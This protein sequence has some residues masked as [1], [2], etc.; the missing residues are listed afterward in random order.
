MFRPPG[1]D[2]V[3]DESQQ[4]VPVPALTAEGLDHPVQCEIDDRFFAV[5]RSVKIKPALECGLALELLADLVVHYFGLGSFDRRDLKLIAALTVEDRRTIGQSSHEW[6]LAIAPTH[7]DEGFPESPKTIVP[8]LPGEDISRHEFLP[9][10]QQKLCP[11]KFAG[12]VFKQLDEFDREFEFIIVPVHS[13]RSCRVAVVPIPLYGRKFEVSRL[14]FAVQNR[15][16][17]VFQ[18]ATMGRDSHLAGRF[19]PRFAS[20]FFTRFAGLFLAGAFAG[21]LA[22]FCPP[23]SASI[24]S[25]VFATRLAGTMP[26]RLLGVQPN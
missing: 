17:I 19:R 4:V 8:Q 25:I 9:R 24:G 22:V 6:R 11:L 12:R 5:L 3:R 15:V 26:V 20:H 2:L 14:D 18:V 21:F 10:L 7:R 23:S 1:V 16:A 13:P